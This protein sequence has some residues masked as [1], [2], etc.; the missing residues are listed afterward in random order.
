MGNSNEKI[1][2]IDRYLANSCAK[3]RE[4]GEHYEALLTLVQ[5]EDP[6]S[7]EQVMA[8]LQD[9]LQDAQG[10][11]TAIAQ[12]LESQA[13]PAASTIL[14]MQQRQDIL[15][16]LHKSNQLLVK[17]AKNIQALIRHELGG[18]ASQQNALKGY[19]PIDSGQTHTISRLF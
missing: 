13:E 2:P 8:S 11:D 19:K 9:L 18:M 16:Q 15:A 17:K 4:I 12:S 6:A 7:V 10:I 1:F 5:N 14:L 3:Y